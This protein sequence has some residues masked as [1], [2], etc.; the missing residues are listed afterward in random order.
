MEYQSMYTALQNIATQA[1]EVTNNLDAQLNQ[2][3]QNYIG[4]YLQQENAKVDNNAKETLA[5]LKEKAQRLLDDGME[6]YQISLDKK[7]FADILPNHV[8]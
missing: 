5:A 3:M 2:N 1:Q 7:Y 6:A 8:G 4:E